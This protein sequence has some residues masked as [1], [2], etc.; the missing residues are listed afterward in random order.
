M[1]NLGTLTLD[2]I[3]KIGGFTG[4]LDQASRTAKKRAREIE[5]S[6][7]GAA[8]A[9]KNAVATLA[10]GAGLNKVIQETV[11]FQ[12]EQA[13]L[14]AVLRSTGE[15]AGYSQEQL[16]D[17]ADAMSRASTLG[18]GDINQAQTTLLAFTGIVGEEF[19]RALQ[20]AVD[21]AARTGM[22]V[23]SAA[24]TI[25]RALDVP[26]KGLSA[27][28]KQGFR[29]TEDQKK[30]AEFLEATG[31]TAE[32][33]A[34][35]LGALEDSYAGAAEAARD[36]LG[37]ALAALGNS[38][39]DLLTGEDGVEDATTAI[40]EFSTTLSD[41]RIKEAFATIT[42][43]V[44]NV[45]NAVA[46]A[47]P[48]LTDFTTWA[49]EELAAAIEGPA[50]G[51]IVR[52]EDR[53]DYLT[54]IA[55]KFQDAGRGV[56]T[57]VSA[58]I[59]ELNYKLEASLQLQQEQQ[60][61][62]AA[63]AQ[64]AVA[65]AAAEKQA[66]AEKATTDAAA[67]A[68]LMQEAKLTAAAEEARKKAEKASQQTAQ[69]AQR[70][71][72]AIAQEIASLQE[73]VAVLGM[74]AD[75]EKLFRLEVKG[76]TDAQIEQA[77][78]ALATVS[79]FEKQQKAQEDYKDLVSDLR[80]EEEQLTDQLKERLRIIEAMPDVPSDERRQMASRAIDQ[81]FSDAPQFSGLDPSVGGPFGEMIKVDKAEAELEDWYAKQLEMLE[82][83]RRDKADLTA[84]W[85]AKE[86][87]L[88]ARHEQGLLT[89]ENARQITA[90]AGAESL[91]GNLANL[92]RT[93]YGEESATYRAV[94][95][96]Q[97]AMAIATT[98]MNAEMAAA[99]ALAPPPF[100]LG[101]VAGLPYSQLIRGIGY[102]SAAVIGAQT[103]VG[104]AHDGIDSVPTTG[105][106]ILEKGER[107]TTAETSA[108][109]D[110]TLSRVQAG[111]ASGRGNGGGNTYN[112]SLPGVTNAREA[113]EASA[114][115]QRG[116]A[117]GVAGSGRYA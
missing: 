17:M 13:Q 96:A 39:N 85:D 81:G 43:G 66:A 88:K 71:A 110:D 98:V 78:A 1:A 32:A 61:A 18:A 82:Q 10:I 113:R 25:G 83:N 92:S 15:A 53:L 105:T 3:A 49:A 29:F 11:N 58:E 84:E 86:M 28:S 48:R 22:S 77:R 31:R 16:N 38:F 109:L 104:M 103:A 59:D 67:Q 90:L 63:A 99:A 34:I 100:G 115:V 114:A 23:V 44:F 26:S 33:Q 47:L 45:A 37:G 62:S 69:A 36:T 101:P 30:L 19:P 102:A 12:N 75:E 50:I 72:E 93:F 24:E 89:L 112:I 117:R 20:A 74:T 55:T 46:Q 2:L 27:L 79:A 7:T 4:P 14:A 56:P 116:I 107:V 5:T 64:A 87:E 40:N 60:L 73:Q 35:I 80:T 97:Q 21:M 52:I 57:K 95:L 111:M 65:R 9:I 8:D 42:A 76:A 108:K 106:W 91:F 68:A 41:P 54:G 70:R 51:D 94:F 6:M